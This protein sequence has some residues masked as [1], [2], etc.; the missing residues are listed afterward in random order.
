MNPTHQ[1]AC[2]I[3]T[4]ETTE[5]VIVRVKHQGRWV[6]LGPAATQAIRQLQRELSAAQGVPSPTT[7]AVTDTAD[8]PERALIWRAAEALAMRGQSNLVAGVVMVAEARELLRR[9]DL[10][11]PVASAADWQAGRGGHQE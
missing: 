3:H 10:T 11:S 6:R 9:I 7:L 4:Q 8:A 2:E 5:R 1:T